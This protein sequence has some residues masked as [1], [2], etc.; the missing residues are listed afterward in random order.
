MAG[1][2]GRGRQLPFPT[3]FPDN[4][5]LRYG[6]Q[7]GP[8]PLCSAVPGWEVALWSTGIMLYSRPPITRGTN[9]TPGADPAP[10]RFPSP[11]ACVYAGYTTHACVPRWVPALSQGPPSPALV[12]LWGS[13]CLRSN[14]AVLTLRSL[15]TGLWPQSATRELRAHPDGPSR[16]RAALFSV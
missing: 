2:A 10:R 12:T 7:R 11:W 15:G 14:R 8:G 3:C 9:S 5:A 6:W 13:F 4:S 1:Q 16:W